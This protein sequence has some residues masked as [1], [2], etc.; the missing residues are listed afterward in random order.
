MNVNPFV[1]NPFAPFAGLNEMR[2]FVFGGFWLLF[3][4]G[5]FIVFGYLTSRIAS[6]KGRNA[7][8]WFFIGAFTGLF[9]LVVSL[10]M[11]PA[12]YYQTDLSRRPPL[13]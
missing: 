3:G 4:L 12:E 8:G 7:A 10:I 1:A 13:T 6:S 9:G 11:L 2:A 5:G